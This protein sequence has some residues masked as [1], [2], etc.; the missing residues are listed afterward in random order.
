[1][2][3][4]E[5]IQYGSLLAK[6]GTGKI[7]IETIQSGH[8][9]A[10]KKET[11]KIEILSCWSFAWWRQRQ[12]ESNIDSACFSTTSSGNARTSTS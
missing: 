7:E 6:K 11:G 4:F 2:S 12:A 1:M 3:V 5:I 9:L 8:L 10:K